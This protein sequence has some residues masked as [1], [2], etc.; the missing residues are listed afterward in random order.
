MV[1]LTSRL[2][3]VVWSEWTHQLEE[4]EKARLAEEAFIAEQVEAGEM[5]LPAAPQRGDPLRQKKELAVPSYEQQVERLDV[6]REED[7][8][9]QEK[10]EQM[11]AGL[12]KL[13]VQ[14][15]AKGDVVNVDWLD[16]RLKGIEDPKDMAQ[17][18]QRR[19]EDFYAAQTR[20]VR[21]VRSVLA[22][23]T[24]ERNVDEDEEKS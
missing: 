16:L 14:L 8:R 1:R 15:V 5:A 2:C 13:R 22:E 11:R 10:L 19:P 24:G 7:R 12:S 3:R 4:T 6:E 9:R 23:V 18:T 17:Q 20:R 21:V